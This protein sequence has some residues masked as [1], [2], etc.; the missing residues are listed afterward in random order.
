[1]A[2]WPIVT[3]TFSLTN[4]LLHTVGIYLLWCLRSQSLLKIQYFFLMSLSGSEL[5]MNFLGVA[6]MFLEMVGKN[7]TPARMVADNIY[8][9]EFTGTA[10]IFHLSMI[11]ITLDRLLE[12][13][14][15]IRYPVYW[16]EDKTKTLLI[17]TWILGTCIS[18]SICCI[19]GIQQFDWAT[20]FFKYFFPSIEIVFVALAFVT[21]TLIFRK[22]KTT[23][24]SPC[25]YN[26]EDADS[27]KRAMSNGSNKKKQES[28]FR[29]FIRS[30]FFIPVL[31]ILTF[32]IFVVGA[33]L[34]YLILIVINGYTDD[35]ISYILTISYAISNLID[36]WIY[37]FLQRDVRRLFMKKVYWK[38][39]HPS[40]HGT[41][42]RNGR[43]T[44]IHNN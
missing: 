37:I 8:I 5:V 33:D 26:P 43:M 22:F 7:N 28:S 14:L 30:K 21:Y 16:D 38:A 18:I 40:R 29:I 12:L 24:Q 9:F 25:N 6:R 2:L 36:A 1:M 4:V 44:T 3:L 31:L 39:F 13:V 32:F 11:F 19:S 34:V 15:N 23:R 42:G 17:G 10:F 35:Y 41:G 27:R 20:Y